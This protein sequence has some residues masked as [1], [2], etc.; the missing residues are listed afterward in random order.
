MVSITRDA[1]SRRYRIRF[2]YGGASYN[3]SLKTTA[4]REAL[5]VCGRVDETIRLLERGSIEMPED[6]DPG[7]FILSDQRLACIG[8]GNVNHC[9]GAYGLHRLSIARFT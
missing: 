3:R 1:A 9:C 7:D 8:V 6:A 4:R 5:S 2:R